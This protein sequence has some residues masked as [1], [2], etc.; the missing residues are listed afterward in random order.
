MQSFDSWF[1]HVQSLVAC[2][3]YNFSDK[4][5]VRDDYDQGK[6]AEDVA[7]DIIDEYS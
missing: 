6:S 2:A 5:S 3:G 7:Q 4:D 1:S